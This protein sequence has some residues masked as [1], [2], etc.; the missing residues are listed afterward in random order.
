MAKTFTQFEAKPSKRNIR[1][2]KDSD[3]KYKYFREW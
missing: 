3:K 2:K 1:I